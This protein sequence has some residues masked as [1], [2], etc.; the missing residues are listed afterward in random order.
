M[1][2]R[3]RERGSSS[4]LIQFVLAHDPPSYAG[5]KE[6]LTLKLREIHDPLKRDKSKSKRRRRQT[7]EFKLSTEQNLLFELG[8]FGNLKGYI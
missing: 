6:S 3:E 7:R 5:N 2:E 4:F 8:L 1:G